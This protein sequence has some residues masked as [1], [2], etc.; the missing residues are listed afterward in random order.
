M[1][2]NLL[3]LVKSMPTEEA[4]RKYLAD[5]RWQDGK[6]VCPYCNH[7]TCYV[8][9]GGKRY[10]CGSRTCYK[11]FSVITGTV[12]EASNVPLTKWFMA[13]YLCT[14][15]KKGISSYQLGKD[16]SVSQKSAWFMLHRIREMMRVKAPVKLD[17]IVEIDPKSA[18]L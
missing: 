2:N 8:I 17:N 11:K 16:I 12:F 13:I 3:E 4:C 9:E 7:S 14:A 18:G 5:Q 1:F 10:K 15:H 6:A